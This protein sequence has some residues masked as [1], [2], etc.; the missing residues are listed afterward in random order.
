M[1]DPDYH[2]RGHGKRAVKMVLDHIFLEK[3]FHKAQ[4]RVY[5]FNEASR[6]LWESLGFTREATLEDHVWSH[7]EYRDVI[8]YGFWREDYEKMD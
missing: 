6:S 1:I 2:G 7:G 3:E 5:A 8:L 4:A